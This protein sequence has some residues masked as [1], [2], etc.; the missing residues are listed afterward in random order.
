VDLCSSCQAF[1]LRCIL[2][3][4][5][6]LLTKPDIVVANRTAVLSS[7][8]ARPSEL[9]LHHA[10][11][12]FCL[13]RSLAGT[14]WGQLSKVPTPSGCGTSFPGAPSPPAAAA[15]AAAAAVAAADRTR[16]LSFRRRCPFPVGVAVK[17]V[18]WCR[19]CAGQQHG[20]AGRHLHGWWPS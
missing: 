19:R 15:A 16:G 11:R 13:F 10:L 9:Y 2:Q 8:Y 5:S 17:L 18:P 20:M 3:L 6:L 1:S 14:W 4:A 12:Y 7:R